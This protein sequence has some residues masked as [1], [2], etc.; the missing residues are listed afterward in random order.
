M[1]QQVLT[2]YRTRSAFFQHL[3]VSLPR[4]RLAAHWLVETDIQLLSMLHPVFGLFTDELSFRRFKPSHGDPRAEGPP[5]HRLCITSL[6]YQRLFI[7]HYVRSFGHFPVYGRGGHEELL[8]AQQITI[9][10]YVV[11]AIQASLRRIGVIIYSLT[12]C[13]EICNGIPR[14]LS[15]MRGA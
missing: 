12:N 8:P 2:S 4:T 15:F 10:G 1:I 9:G 6:V 11:A 13:R 3:H 5:Y 7:P 14:L